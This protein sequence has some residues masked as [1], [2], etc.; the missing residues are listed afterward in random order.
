MIGS[1]RLRRVA[2]PV[3]VALLAA[4]MLVPGASVAS[5][6][7][8][9]PACDSPPA[10]G[11]DPFLLPAWTDANGWIDPGQ[12]ETI[13][14]GDVDGD[15]RGELLGR[16]GSYM[17]VNQWAPPL[18]SGDPDPGQWMTVAAGPALSDDGGW[19]DPQYYTTIQLADL[20]GNGADDLLARG[21]GGMAAWSF[22]S[23]TWTPLPA[24][25][26]WSDAAGWDQTPQYTTIQTGDLDGDG[27]DDLLGL[28][29]NNSE[30]SAFSYDA[31]TGTWQP[32]PTLGIGSGWGGPEYY[33]TIQTADL[34]GNGSDEILARGSAGIVAWSLAG[35][36]WAALSAGP[37]WSDANGWNQP[38]QVATIQTADV[39]GDGGAEL[40]GLSDTA[41]ETYAFESGSWVWVGAND[42][43]FPENPW[44]SEQYYSTI[45][46]GDVDGDGAAELLARGP[47]GLQ[48]WELQANTWGPAATTF[49]ELSDAG[50][51]DQPQYYATIDAVSVLV[52]QPEVLIARSNMG[53]NTWELSGTAPSAAWVSTSSGFPEW[54]QTPIDV[55]DPLQRAYQYIN[56]QVGKVLWPDDTLPDGHWVPILTK[57]QDTT[58]S[59]TAIQTELANVKPR[60][61]NIPRDDWDTVHQEMTAW[62]NGV[63][64][65]VA[66]FYGQGD[67][68]SLQSLADDQ[69]MLTSNILQQIEADY[70]NISGTEQILAIV[71]A[72]LAA[73]AAA[74]SALVDPVELPLLV[75]GLSLL[76]SGL[77]SW[78]GF[79]NPQGK[80]QAEYDQL[81]GQLDDAFCNSTYFIDDAY[82]QIVTDYGLLTVVSQLVGDGTWGWSGNSFADA[83]AQMNQGQELWAFQQLGTV[84]WQAGHCE[85]NALG[86]YFCLFGFNSTYGFQ[87][88][89]NN[90]GGFVN[91]QPVTDCPG[92]DPKSAWDYLV[93]SLG[94]RMEDVFTPLDPQ[95]GLAVG[96]TVGSR[97]WNLE[98]DDCTGWHV[99][100]PPVVA[101]GHGAVRRRHQP[102]GRAG[103]HHG[104]GRGGGAVAVGIVPLRRHRGDLPCAGRA[105]PGHDLHR[106]RRRG[107]RSVR[108]E[109]VPG[110]L[111][112]PRVPAHRGH[113]RADHRHRGGRLRLRGHDTA[114]TRHHRGV[115]RA[116]LVRRAQDRRRG[117]EPGAVH[118]R[119]PVRHLPAD[120]R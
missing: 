27:S 119:G 6:G 8:S 33:T 26:S 65:L 36:T 40:L 63:V 61:L 49:A 107:A 98:V 79:V 59:A 104:G 83:V 102:R 19:D 68:P 60:G 70:F 16:N 95:T 73:V 62:V 58:Q 101:T 89:S 45:Q 90:A 75:I 66:Y 46:T 111:L 100:H 51:W 4:T 120:G 87:V 41:L 48:A 93:N 37:P 50:G 105:T 81:L 108:D 103:R 54:V 113:H 82:G 17:D 14:A 85:P 94:V 3:S 25:P 22:S 53:I 115:L 9:P 47:D 1:A 2:V 99:S 91:W 35:G 88:P 86:D 72:V 18:Q 64:D 10:P 118:L 56:D 7:S 55:D 116:L 114:R 112:R 96:D 30:I 76:G 71:S 78:Q 110:R 77:S 74:A 5:A 109:R 34:D 97:G 24:G 44:A 31:A 20:D 11:S 29:P 21:G 12:Y 92:S 67:G 15:G 57:L 117:R 39:D 38:E 32:L 52:G 80:I 69:L 28:D 43:P 13:I 42:V 23:G 84:A 106:R